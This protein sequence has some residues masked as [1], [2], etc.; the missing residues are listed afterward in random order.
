[1]AAKNNFGT[2]KRWAKAFNVSDDTAENGLVIGAE[3]ALERRFQAASIR[4]SS[5]GVGS[6]VSAGGSLLSSRD[7]ST[8]SAAYAG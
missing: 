2:P 5:S 7:I 8:S 1:M 4:S 3:V 6:G